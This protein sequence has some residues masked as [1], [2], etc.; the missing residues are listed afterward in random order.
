[1]EV[2]EHGYIV[3]LSVKEAEKIFDD[4]FLNAAGARGNGKSRTLY[5]YTAAW[6]KIKEALIEKEKKDEN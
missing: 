6:I 2:N 4:L 5:N 3:D 1:M